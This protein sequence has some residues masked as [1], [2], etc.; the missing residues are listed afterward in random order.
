MS[1]S[2]SRNPV[3][4]FSRGF[5]APFR[6][7]RFL[8]S[9]PALLKYV[10]IP[11]LI[12]LVV[13]SG[14]VY[15]GFDFFNDSVVNMIP[16]GEAWYWA[17]LY[18]FVWVVAVLVTTIIVFF[19]FTVIGNLIASP[20]NDLL[21]ERTE[22]LLTGVKNEDSFSLKQFGGDA[23]RT[24]VTE[25]KKLSAFVGVMLFLLL[26][27]FIPGIGSAIYSVLAVALTLFFLVVEYMGYVFSRKRMM[28][29]AQRRYIFSR[30]LKMLGFGTGVLALLAI[31]FLQF[32]CIPIAVV[33]GTQLWCEDAEGGAALEKQDSEVL[34][35]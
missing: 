31:P 12:N 2:S 11:F 3:S 17:L 1:R 32:A 24:L 30:N 4:N 29:R 10:V 33:G 22:Q 18:Y 27:N 13:F 15:L 19:S 16:Q 9:H 5:F 21:S 20:F 25:V 6:S 28:F 8:M 14:S 26:L 35:S 23:L 7:I 34:N